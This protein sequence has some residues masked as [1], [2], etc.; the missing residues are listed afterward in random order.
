MNHLISGQHFNRLDTLTTPNKLR[1]VPEFNETSRLL[2]KPMANLR[3]RL[4]RSFVRLFTCWCRAS[5]ESTVARDKPTQTRD[6][7]E[8]TAEMLPFQTGGIRGEPHAFKV[9]DVNVNP[10]SLNQ[11]I[12]KAFP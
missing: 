9:D 4:S 8:R 5:A 11:R 2:H 10:F 12:H 6:G 1:T 3:G 7:V